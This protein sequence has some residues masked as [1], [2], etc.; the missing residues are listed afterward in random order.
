MLPKP[1]LVRIDSS[2]VEQLN[3][4]NLRTPDRWSGNNDC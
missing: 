2:A 4:E 1:L 3:F